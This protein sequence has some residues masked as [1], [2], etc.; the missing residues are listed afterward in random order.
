MIDSRT[1]RKADQC[2]VSTG[3]GIGRGSTHT[4]CYI[5]YYATLRY[6]DRWITYV[7]G[8]Q[9]PMKF[10]L[11]CMYAL[12]AVLA[13]FRPLDNNRDKRR[14]LYCPALH[15]TFRPL[16]DTR[17]KRPRLCCTAIHVIF[18][19]LDGTR[20]ERLKL[21]CPALHA[22]FLPLDAT[23]GK[24]LTL[25]CPALHAIFCPVDGTRGKRLTLY[26]PAIL[27]F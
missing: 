18:R 4:Q 15:A 1:E 8:R 26:Y 6:I 23:R 17:G 24:R 10:K 13:V 2:A 27:E 3:R 19:P 16:D 5:A 21:Y 12:S 25:Y 9:T 22:I 14:K 20:D 11:Y 7:V